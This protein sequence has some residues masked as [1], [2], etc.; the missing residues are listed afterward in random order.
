MSWLFT[1]WTWLLAIVLF[2]A[3][4]YQGREDGQSEI[5]ARQ[6][7]AIESAVRAA[8]EQ[9]LLEAEQTHGQA[10]A[11]EADREQVRTVYV[12]V[13]E[14]AN[15]NIDR[16]T[17]YNDCSLD[18]DG[19][20]LYN[21]RP[22]TDFTAAPAAR[23][24]DGVVSGSAASAGWPAVNPAAQQPGTRGSVLRVPGAAQGAGG[25]GNRHPADQKEIGDGLP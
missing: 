5:Q 15:E 1:H 21:A 10:A 22:T 4:Y 17:G 13:K 11:F 23:L 25:V 24:A 8:R 12:H 16:N 9:A 19:L 14:K 2:L 7:Q 20:R 18:A 6:V 3:G